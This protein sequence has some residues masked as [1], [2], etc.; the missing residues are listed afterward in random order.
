M[1]ADDM[2]YVLMAGLAFFLA[3]E[4]SYGPTDM[5]TGL[6]LAAKPAN[7]LYTYTFSGDI[8]GELT[9]VPASSS[10]P[11]KQVSAS[12]LSFEFPAAST[13]DTTACNTDQPSLAPTVND[14]DGYA[15]D[16]W[17]GAIDLSRRKKSSFH[18]QITGTQ[19]D[20][21]GSINLAVNDVPVEDTN[22]GGTAMIR[23]EDA[24]A[25]ISALSY[26]E[27]D[28]N[29]D[30]TYDAEDRCVNFSITATPP[31]PS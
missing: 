8:Q 28:G 1:H 22:V 26:S 2:R 10:D 29:G 17:A 24:R 5:A 16:K 9:N 3:C 27:T 18:L 12:G 7:A 14:W 25:L 13:A 6:E 19:N 30:P 4:E 31:P 15:S 21:T 20:G 23:F 11:F